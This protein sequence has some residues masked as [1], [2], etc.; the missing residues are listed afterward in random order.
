MPLHLQWSQERCNSQPAPTIGWL[1]ERFPAV[2]GH[3]REPTSTVPTYL[4][5]GS[6]AGKVLRLNQMQRSL[7]YPCQACG[8]GV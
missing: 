1:R 2:A 7:K 6:Y 5:R 4:A 8:D 3:P